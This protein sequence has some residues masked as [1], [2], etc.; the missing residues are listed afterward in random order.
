MAVDLSSLMKKQQGDCLPKR[1]ESE[2]GGQRQDVVDIECGEEIGVFAEDIKSQQYGDERERNRRRIVRLE[3]MTQ[4]A[5]GRA[6]PFQQT[7]RS[8]M[9][10]GAHRGGDNPRF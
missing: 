5:H 4:A 6:G 2:R 10:S 7:A 3:E 8:D 9:R 1:N